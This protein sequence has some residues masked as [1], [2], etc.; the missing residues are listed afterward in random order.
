MALSRGYI[1]HGGWLDK[2]PKRVYGL[3]RVQKPCARLVEEYVPD[4]R[5]SWIES[6]RYSKLIEKL[7]GISRL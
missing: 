7:G 1:D 3:S 2:Q 5:L 6:H 4:V